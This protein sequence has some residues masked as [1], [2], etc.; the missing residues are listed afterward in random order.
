MSRKNVVQ[1]R[2]AARRLDAP[3]GRRTGAT[4]APLPP[5]ASPARYPAPPV[6]HRNKINRAVLATLAAT[7]ATAPAR[8][9][10]ED[11]VVTATKRE[12][13][14]QDVPVAVTALQEDGLEELRIGTFDDYVQYLPNVV[15]QGTGPGQN[16]IFIRGAATSQTIISLSSASGLQPGVALYVDEQPVALQ[17]RNL[18]VYVTD[19]QRVEVVTGPQGTVFGASSQSGTVRLITNKPDHDAFQAD[20]QPL[21]RGEAALV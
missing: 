12:E 2:T 3:T 5:A 16:E 14:L 20:P 4:R 13:S 18:D 10:I 6:F 21:D 15:Y 19:M 1:K 17:G 8:A 9:A 11:I 7:V